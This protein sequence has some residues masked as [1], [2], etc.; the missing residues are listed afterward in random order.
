MGSLPPGWDYRST[1]VFLS[2]SIGFHVCVNNILPTKSFSYSQNSMSLSFTV[3]QT[4]FFCLLFC[5]S[6]L[7]IFVFIFSRKFY[8]FILVDFFNHFTRPY[9]LSVFTGHH[10]IL[11]F[12]LDR[13]PECFPYALIFC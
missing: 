9:V 7:R 4:G 12:K 8:F 11:M 10:A 6:K 2:F 5:L 13:F 3:H 1:Q